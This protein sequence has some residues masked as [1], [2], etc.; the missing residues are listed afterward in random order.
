MAAAGSQNS[1]PA[2]AP[3]PLGGLIGGIVNLATVP[4]TAVT[5]TLGQLGLPFLVNPMS[6]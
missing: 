3:G 5:G 2:I 4:I 1:Q 6:G